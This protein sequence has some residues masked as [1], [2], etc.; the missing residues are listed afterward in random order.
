MSQTPSF[1]DF[2]IDRTRIFAD[3]QFWGVSRQILPSPSLPEVDQQFEHTAV[4][5]DAGAISS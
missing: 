2:F 4:T 5:I 3:R 1:A